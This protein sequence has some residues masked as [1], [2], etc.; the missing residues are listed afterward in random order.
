[1]INYNKGDDEMSRQQRIKSKSGYYHIMLRGNER[2]NV[3]ND[4]D[5]KQQF[6]EELRE[7]KKTG[8]IY[9]LFV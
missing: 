7:K 8:S 3:F 6:L 1:L 2:K 5:D 4:D 9:I